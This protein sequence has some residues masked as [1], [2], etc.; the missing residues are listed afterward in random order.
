FA[1]ESMLGISSRPLEHAQRLLSFVHASEIGT[2]GFFTRKR[3]YYRG[4][5]QFSMDEISGMLLGLQFLARA[6]RQAAEESLDQQVSATAS[7]RGRFLRDNQYMIDPPPV[8]GRGNPRWI[9]GE[10]AP[11]SEGAAPPHSLTGQLAGAKAA[12]RGLL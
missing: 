9:R 11:S 8:P 1:I 4:T 5:D 2:T 10:L 7:R 3:H 12:V 6:A